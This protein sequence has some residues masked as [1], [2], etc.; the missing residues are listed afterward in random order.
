[1]MFMLIN[2]LIN[3]YLLAISWKGNMFQLVIC[4]IQNYISVIDDHNL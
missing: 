4:I 2:A 3:L 1:M